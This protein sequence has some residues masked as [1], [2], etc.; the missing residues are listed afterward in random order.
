M[1]ISECCQYNRERGHTHPAQPVVTCPA[2]TPDNDSRTPQIP[3]LVSFPGDSSPST[4][5]PGHLPVCVCPTVARRIRNR[6]MSVHWPFLLRL[7][8]GTSRL[9]VFLTGCQ[10]PPALIL[11]PPPRANP[12]FCNRKNNT[13][14]IR[15]FLEQP[16][17]LSSSLAI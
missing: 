15:V 13:I 5:A 9:W 8:N 1:D 7:P 6:D 2:C 14:K 3:K 12:P 16:D 4:E 10:Q 17:S 11:P